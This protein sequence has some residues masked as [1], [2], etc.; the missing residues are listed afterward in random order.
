MYEDRYSYFG[1]YTGSSVF[2]ILYP[3]IGVVKQKL[4]VEAG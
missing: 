4:A 3:A 2:L 1:V